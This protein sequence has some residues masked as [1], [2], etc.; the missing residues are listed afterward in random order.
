MVLNSEGMTYSEPPPLFTEVVFC[1]ERVDRKEHR[2]PVSIHGSLVPKFLPSTN[3][4]TL[5][6]LRS[7]TNI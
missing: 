6:S 3:H 7:E 2:K 1:I 4:K 5:K